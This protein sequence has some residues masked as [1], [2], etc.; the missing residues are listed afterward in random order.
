[1]ANSTLN[2]DIIGDD[3]LSFTEGKWD[4]L[5]ESDQRVANHFWKWLLVHDEGLIAEG[6]NTNIEVA[7]HHAEVAYNAF[8]EVIS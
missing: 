1:M 6:A 5:I 8:K 2:F 3:F 7:K 4:I